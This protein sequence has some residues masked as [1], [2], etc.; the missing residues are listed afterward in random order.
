MAMKTA[1]LK[2]S[3]TDLASDILVGAGAIAMYLFGDAKERKRVY[4]FAS[5]SSAKGER[6]PTF[7][8][9]ATIC[10]RRTTLRAWIAAKEGRATA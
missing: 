10:A 2:S 3:E 4:Y 7:K 5:P 8:I 6:I 1:K 9:G